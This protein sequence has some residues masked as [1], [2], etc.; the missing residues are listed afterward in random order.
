MPYQPRQ[1]PAAAI[2]HA[3]APKRG[4]QRVGGTE[5]TH[6][7]R[8]LW[9]GITK[10]HLAEYWTKLAPRAL[11][12]IA[13]RPLALLRCPDGIDGQRF[14]QKHG[15]KGMPP[16]IREGA[17]EGQPYLAIE[18]ESGLLACAQ[19]A[20]IELHGW[21][22]TLADPA[23][24]DRLVL[25]LDPGEGVGFA[26]VVKSAL[27]LRKRLQAM[28]L[29]SL[30]RTTGGKGLHLVV[31]LAPAAGWNAVRDFAH[32]IARALEAEAPERF[33]SSVPKAKRRGRILVDWLRNG[34]G[35][36]AICSYSLRA[37]PGATVATPLAWREV[38]AKLDPQAFTLGTVPQRVARQK[39]DPWAE[40][41]QLA[42]RLPKEKP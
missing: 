16:E 12:E 39:R 31:P 19:M 34:V 8:E 14:F 32:G 23:H 15:N 11:A 26:E 17:A 6:A 40:L 41:P 36:T 42:Q 25:D 38:N 13:G 10:Q 18:G 22:A 21:G 33:V 29:E 1:R 4:A 28:G 35:A 5:I 30:C 2:V 7:D 27:E 37:R 9:P 24:P 20:A 3:T